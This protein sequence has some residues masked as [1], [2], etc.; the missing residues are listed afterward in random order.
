MATRSHEM[1][2]ASRRFVSI[3]ERKVV[4]I[5]TRHSGRRLGVT[6]RME[7]DR[8]WQLFLG[9]RMWRWTRRPDRSPPRQLF[10]LHRS[11]NGN[12][13]YILDPLDAQAPSRLQVAQ[14]ALEKFDTFYPELLLKQRVSLLQSDMLL[15]DLAEADALWISNLA[16]PTNTQH[17]LA[18][19]LR[20]ELRN[21]T[22]SDIIGRDSLLDR[23]NE[24]SIFCLCARAGCILV[25]F[26]IRRRRRR[27]RPRRRRRQDVCRA[28]ELEPLAQGQ[29][30]RDSKKGLVLSQPENRNVGN[31]DSIVVVLRKPCFV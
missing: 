27:R 6:E 26:P 22:V 5:W 24:T 18:D 3:R 17:L 9:S 21:Q 20:S 31:D 4:D 25:S 19:K 8:R 23:D 30:A 10:L 7:E 29:I 2:S 28:H 12:E 1:G 11:R 13:F 14:A 16:L 15:A